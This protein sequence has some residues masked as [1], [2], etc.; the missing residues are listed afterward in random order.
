MK[1]LYRLF[2]LLAL[3]C[4][5]AGAKAQNDGVT[6]TL[7]PQMPYSNFFNPGI[8][9]PYKAIVG[10]GVSNINLSVY[11]SSLKYGN[12]YGKNA[13]GEDVIDGVKLFN[14]LEE[15]DNFINFNMSFDV[16]NIGFRINK[17][18][19]NIDYRN[20]INSEFQYSKDFVGFFVKGNGYY[21]GDNPCDFNIGVDGTIYS[22]LGVGLQ[23]D[24]TEHFTIGVRPKLLV[25]I[26]N[27]K[28]NNER[29][30]IYTDADD[31]SISADVNLNIRMANTF[32]A[33]MERM[34]D[35][36]KFVD[37][38][39]MELKDFFSI[40]KNF[41]MG[42][43]FG[44]SYVF[45]KHF[46]LSAGAYDIGFI[47]WKNTKV[48]NVS[49]ENLEINKTLFNDIS[50]ITDMQLDYESM[51]DNVVKQVWGNDSLVAGD[52][53]TT[54]LKS[55]IMLQGYYE[56]HPTIR[57]TAVAQMYYVNGQ[58]RPAMTVAY[59]G[60]FLNFLNLSL[61]YTNSKYAGSSLGAG[62]GLHIGILNLYAVTDNISIASKMF[63][64][65][66]EMMTSFDSANFR[67]GVVLTLGKY[68]SLKRLFSKSNAE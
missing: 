52:D 28:V 46:G 42:V 40:Q 11:S 39:N 4:L 62:I 9:V 54:Y 45:N 31:Y 19:V 26:A 37:I 30:K 18:F 14:S 48:K 60:A 36:I 65:T 57:F 21:V 43:D 63:S 3:I 29:T 2:V 15:Q 6:F 49:K 61:S 47:R 27:V 38:E 55:K 16:F 12:I 33:S 59:S 44:L 1:R 22:E 53:Y 50:Q 51:L 67:V 64:S 68:Q 7:L 20:K 35:I 66:M 25:G 13:A 10:V 41:G 8:R 17:L 56:L 5:T 34:G 32:N 58:M 24:V 23:Y